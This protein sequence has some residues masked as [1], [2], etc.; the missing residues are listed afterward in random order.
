MVRLYSK[1]KSINENGTRLWHINTHTHI[2]HDDS[3]AGKEIPSFKK[4]A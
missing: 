1:S 4:R 3:G 2:E